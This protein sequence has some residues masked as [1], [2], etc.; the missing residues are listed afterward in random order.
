MKNTQPFY[1]KIASIFSDPLKL[2]FL[3][4]SDDKQKICALFNYK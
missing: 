2:D 4:N 1:L 3:S